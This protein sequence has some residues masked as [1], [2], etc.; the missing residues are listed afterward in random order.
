MGAEQP[1]RAAPS[2]FVGDHTEIPLENHSF[3]GASGLSILSMGASPAPQG[4]SARFRGRTC[5]NPFRKSYFFGRVWIFQFYRV[6]AHQPRR[7]AP[8]VFVGEH[9]KIPLE[10]HCFSGRVWLFQFYRVVRISPAG[11]LRAVS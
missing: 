6:G 9:A 3:L 1:L 10:N 11:P 8:R 2:G 4:R 7:A 5:E